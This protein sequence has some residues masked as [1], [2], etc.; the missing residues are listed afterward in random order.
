M[1]WW[2]YLHLGNWQCHRSGSIFPENWFL[3]LFFS[4]DL[5][6]LT[7]QPDEAPELR[8]HVIPCPLG[9][10]VCTRHTEAQ[11]GQVTQWAEYHTERQTA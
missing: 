4:L 6:L 11:G 7:G 3:N 9:D 5:T 2:E 1:L 8:N 10:L